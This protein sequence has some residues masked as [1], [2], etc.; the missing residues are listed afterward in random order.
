MHLA[1]FS[2]LPPSL[3]SS[4]SWSLPPVVAHLCTSHVSP[5]SLPSFKLPTSITSTCPKLIPVPSRCFEIFKPT[6]VEDNL[7]S[8][9]PLLFLLP[10]LLY[11]SCLFPAHDSQPHQA[12]K[13]ISRARVRLFRSHRICP[14]LPEFPSDFVGP[15]L[16]R[17]AAAF[18]SAARVRQQLER[19]PCPVSTRVHAVACVAPA[20]RA[21]PVLCVH[22]TR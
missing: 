15:P 9:R 21:G 20:R 2:H 3:S 11:S 17:S 1:L 16:L 14:H 18:K 10:I 5:S 13:A 12:F 7:F 19:C 6:T 22:V 4:L 8:S